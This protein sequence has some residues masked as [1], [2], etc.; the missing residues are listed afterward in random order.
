MSGINTVSV[1]NLVNIDKH[2]D[3][4]HRTPVISQIQNHE[5]TNTE[6][7][8]RIKRP[9]ELER[10]DGKTVDPNDKKQENPRKKRVKPNLISA[11]SNRSLKRG[12]SDGHFVDVCA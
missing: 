3:D 5:L 9:A 10:T 7:E 1:S 2:Q 8:Q 6:N 11:K 12:P 4:L